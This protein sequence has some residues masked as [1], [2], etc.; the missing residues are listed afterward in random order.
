MGTNVRGGILE[1]VSELGVELMVFPELSKSLNSIILFFTKDGTHFPPSFWRGR[2]CS[3]A[4]I[5]PP[6]CKPINR[7]S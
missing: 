7:D 3:P 1:K 5:P 4:F 2:G 6:T